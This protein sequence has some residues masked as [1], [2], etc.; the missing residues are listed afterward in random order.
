MERYV[1]DWGDANGEP[2][3]A[4]VLEF[5]EEPECVTGEIEAGEYE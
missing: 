3:N 4:L 2:K 5:E 1:A